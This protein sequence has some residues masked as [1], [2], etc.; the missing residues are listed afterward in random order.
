MWRKKD[1]DCWSGGETEIGWL[2]FQWLIVSSGECKL[3][4]KKDVKNQ[5][6]W[7]CFFDD[8]KWMD[9]QQKERK[10]CEMVLIQWQTLVQRD[11]TM[12]VWI[13]GESN[14]KV[15]WWNCETRQDLIKCFLDVS[16]IFFHLV[17]SDWI[18]SNRS[19]TL[20]NKMT[21]H[22]NLAR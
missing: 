22:Q 9:K 17:T 12:L 11:W 6:E 13:E 1:V 8:Q 4:V 18:W 7:K 19:I 16:S 5:I 3:W 15:T 21:K 20:P 14:D 10:N 2:S